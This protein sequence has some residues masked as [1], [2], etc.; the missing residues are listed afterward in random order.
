[1]GAQLLASRIRPHPG[2]DPHIHATLSAIQILVMQEAIDRLDKPMVIQYILSLF[3]PER[4]SFSGDSWGETDARFSYCA[5]AALALLDSLHRLDRHK[6]V[7]FLARCQNFDGGFGMV[8]G[9]ESHAAYVWTCVAALAILDRLD[10]VNA[11]TLGW[12]LS[13]RQVPN[14]GLNG[15]PEKLEDVCYSWWALATLVIIGKPHWID[16]SKLT[17]FILSC[18]DPDG[19]GI[20][21][22]PDDMPDVWHTVFGL[23]GLSMLGYE[24]LK[25]VDPVFCMPAQFTKGLVKHEKKS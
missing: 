17:S 7:A 4:G 24:G 6:T 14:G 22:R 20:A 16:Q 3:D 9:A 10:I 15:R 21:D 25:P 12:W 13:E 2:H 5:V 1:M 23:A 8:E 18:Q 19:G 11:N